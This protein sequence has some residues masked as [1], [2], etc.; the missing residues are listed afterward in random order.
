MFI[1]LQKKKENI[2]E[3][4]LYMFQVEDML[5]ATKFDMEAIRYTIAAQ[6]SDEQDEQDEVVAW[7]KQLAQQMEHEGIVEKGHLQDIKNVIIELHYLHTTLL[8]VLRDTDYE[9]VYQAAQTY[10]EEL[11]TKSGG[12]TNEIELMLN[13]LYAKLLL[14]LSGKKI[15]KETEEAMEDFRKVLAHLAHAYNLMRQG[16]LNAPLN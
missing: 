9:A 2:V 7:Y 15:G 5:R 13:A 12:V 4:L 11:K 3:Y 8:N 10:L 6:Q 1:A 16:Q 14:R